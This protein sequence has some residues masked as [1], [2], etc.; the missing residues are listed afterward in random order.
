M[1]HTRRL[2]FLFCCFAALT[3]WQANPLPAQIVQQPLR[4]FTVHDGLAQQQVTCLFQDSRGYIWV[5]TKAGISKF[6]GRHFENFRLADSIPG[7]MPLAFAEDRQG[8]IW[9]VTSRG[10]GYYDGIK[11]RKVTS[12]ALNELAVCGELVLASN[13]AD[14]KIW[15]LDVDSARVVILQDTLKLVGGGKPVA[16]FMHELSAQSLLVL[17]FDQKR[18]LVVLDTLFRD[19]HL[20]TPN[21]MFRP[22]FDFKIAL[23]NRNGWSLLTRLGS[24][25]P[26]D[27][28]HFSAGLAAI[29]SDMNF[30]HTPGG[31]NYYSSYS[32]NKVFQTQPGSKEALVLDLPIS[33]PTTL[34][35]DRD[36]AIW[37]G[38]EDGLYQYFPD[39]FQ[40]ISAETAPMPWSLVED[41]DGGYYIG[42]YGYGL[43]RWYAEK[44]ETVKI[45]ASIF[46]CP[47]HNLFYFGATRDRH[48]NLYF[49]HTCGLIQKKGAVFKNLL[50]TQPDPYKAILQSVYDEKRNKILAGTMGRVYVYDPDNGRLDSI[51]FPGSTRFILSLAIDRAGDY[52]FSSVWKGVVRYNPESKSVTY[53]NPETKELPFGGALCMEPDPERGMW[54]GSYR[55]LYFRDEDKQIFVRVAAHGIGE[56]VYNLKVVD[57][58]LMIGDISGLYALNLNAWRRDRSEQVKAYNQFNGFSGIEPNQNCAMLDSKGNYWV[59]CSNQ[60]AFLH[61]SKISLNDHPSRVRIFQINRQRVP[62]SGKAGIALPEGENE[63][64]VRFESIGFQQ[65]LRTQYSWRL[66]GR[67]DAWGAWS[68]DAIAYFSQLPSGRYTFEV[69]SRHP[70]SASETDVE[71]DR[72]AFQVTL[73]LY[74]EPHFYQYAFFAGGFALLLGFF[75]LGAWRKARAEVHKANEMAGEREKMIKYYQVQTLQAQLNPHF[76]FNLLETIQQFVEQEKTA[77]AVQQIQRLAKLLRRFMESSINSDLDKIRDGNRDISLASEIELLTYYIELEQIQKPGM[78]TYAIEI[79]NDLEPG[80]CFITPMIIQPFVENAIKRGLIPKPDAPR[81]VLLSLCRHNEDIRCRIEDN[82]IGRDASRELQA[83]S[84]RKFKSRGVTL[85][86]DRV[87]LLAEMDIPIAI[88]ISDRPGG[89]TVVTIDFGI[90]TTPET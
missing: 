34:I 64:T 68:E 75:A 65:P 62:Y 19:K 72:Y 4:H 85:V 23:P 26:F 15:H 37:F 71:T 56:T 1:S 21:N 79:A 69:R 70:G 31:I 51:I 45:P 59:V 55:G 42:S 40:S 7:L 35:R 25:M 84:V 88:N 41:N 52:W 90:T 87:A 43:K 63:V 14:N 28:I 8:N 6:N 27:S 20:L 86:Q 32:N 81:H 82:G 44:M 48:G 60:I 36:G 5:G 13:S 53:F 89:G 61:K 77:D 11:W 12:F 24:N 10:S 9:T 76:I 30:L 33:T 83:R 54:F 18:Q 73:P 57:S 66:L 29:P 49:P 58:L 47:Q 3:A 74:R 39:G 38:A 46:P 78:F 67:S 80:N 16:F 22:G 17:G 2:C 50:R